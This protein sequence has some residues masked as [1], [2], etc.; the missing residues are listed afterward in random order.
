MP[1][2]RGRRRREDRLRYC[3]RHGGWAYRRVR[4][5]CHRCVPALRGDW[6][7][8][9]VGWDVLGHCHWGGQGCRAAGALR[10][11]VAGAW[12][13]AG[14]RFLAR[15]RQDLLHGGAAVCPPVPGGGSAGRACPPWRG[16]RV[17][18][19]RRA[20]VEPPVGW[21]CRAAQRSEVSGPELAPVGRGW[22]RGVVRAWRQ[23]VSEMSASELWESPQPAWPEPGL[24]WPV[25]VWRRQG[26]PVRVARSV[27]VAVLLQLPPAW[28]PWR[29][30]PPR[31]C[32]PP[33][34]APVLPVWRRQDGSEP[35]VPG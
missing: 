23:S 32:S 27:A 1:V 6:G 14:C 11:P 13:A 30:A 15:Y 5:C 20:A 10:F 31:A 8:P 21:G 34:G 33:E 25:P 9:P 17:W 24:V 3:C 28:P 4:G 26:E 35:V 29:G 12:W 7:L 16:H 2:G 18:P 19:V 22:L